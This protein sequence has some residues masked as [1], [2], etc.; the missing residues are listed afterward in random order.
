MVVRPEPDEGLLVVF[1]C[2]LSYCLKK[3]GT[4][5]VCISR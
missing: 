2:L 5:V 4:V 1:D 3:L